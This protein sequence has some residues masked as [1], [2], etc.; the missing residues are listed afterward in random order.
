MSSVV[1]AVAVILACLPVASHCCRR[2]LL[3]PEMLVMSGS[4]PGLLLGVL[5]DGRRSHDVEVPEF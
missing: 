1:L 5:H 4:G 3:A 2:W